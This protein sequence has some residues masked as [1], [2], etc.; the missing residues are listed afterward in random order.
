MKQAAKLVQQIAKITDTDP[1]LIISRSRLTA[2]TRCRFMV[3]AYLSREGQSANSIAKIF[4]VHH[5]AV[6]YGLRRHVVLMEDSRGYERDF[7]ELKNKFDNE[8]KIT[9]LKSK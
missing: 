1:A 6:L 5:S 7:K 4:D 9:N 8:L 2:V 3:W